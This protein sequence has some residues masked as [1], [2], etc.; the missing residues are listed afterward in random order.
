M[1]SQ[2]VYQFLVV[3]ILIFPLKIFSQQQIPRIAQKNPHLLMI[4]EEF[5][6]VSVGIHTYTGK[7]LSHKIFIQNNTEWERI[8]SAYCRWPARFEI[9]QPDFYSLHLGFFCYKEMQFEKITYLPLRFR[10]GSLEYV[11]RMEGKR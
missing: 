10:L 5:Q 6:E 8:N 7:Q 3:L 2:R 9:I 11:N 1:K 4:P